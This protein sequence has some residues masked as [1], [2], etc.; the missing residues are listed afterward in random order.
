MRLVIDLDTCILAG[1][2]IYNHPELFAWD[3]DNQPLVIRPEVETEAEQRDAAQAR[4]LCPSGAIS[5][6]DA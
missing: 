5:M 2:C 4:T 1:E 3:P 6:V